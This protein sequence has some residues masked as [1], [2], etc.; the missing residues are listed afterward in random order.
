MPALLR[1]RAVFMGLTA[2]SYIRASELRMHLNLSASFLS[3]SVRN[4]GPCECGGDS[5]LFI[6]LTFL[7]SYPEF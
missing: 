4:V 5:I 1:S 3:S 2:D 6:I 7:H